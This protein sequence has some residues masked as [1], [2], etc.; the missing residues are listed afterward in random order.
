MLSSQ[1]ARF[2]IVNLL[3]SHDTKIIILRIKTNTTRMSSLQGSIGSR[4]N[5]HLV[6][7]F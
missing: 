4:A 7:R 5:I 3:T 2:I 6:G 1:V